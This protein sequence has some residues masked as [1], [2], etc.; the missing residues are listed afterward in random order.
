MVLSAVHIFAWIFGEAVD[1]TANSSGELKT[2]RKETEA[3]VLRLFHAEGWRRNTIAKQLG[4]HHSAV[5]RVLA[6]NGLLP[7]ARRQRKSMSDEFVPFIRQTLEK[8]PKLAATRLHQ[9]VKSR[10]YTGGIDHFRDIVATLRPTPKGEAYLRLSTLPGEQ[11]QCDWAHFGKLTVGNAE[12]R[13]LAFVMVLSWSRNIFLRFYFGDSTANFLRGH[14]EAFEYYNSVPREV[15]YDN[16]KSAVLERIGDAIHFNPDLLS[17]AAHYRFAPK[18]VAVRKANQKGRVERAISYIRTSFFAGREFADIDELNEQA[19]AWCLEESLSRKQPP[20]RLQTVGE[21]FEKERSSLMELPAAPFPVYERKPVQAGKTP[22]VRF[23]LNDYSVPYKYAN[24]RLIV[25]ATLKWVY[26]TNGQELVATHPRVFGKGQTV[27][28]GEHLKELVEF[29]KKAKKHRPMDR[30]RNV[31]PSSEVYYKHAAERGHNLGRLT[32]LLVQLL[33]LYGAAEME[34]AVAETVASGVFH[35]ATIQ[36]I[37]ERNR[38]RRGVVPPVRL[39]FSQRKLEELTV[40]PGGLE[41]YDN[42]AGGRNE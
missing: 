9:M 29:K 39:H 37:L 4:L 6:R 10:G 42:L 24:D 30:I 21:A 3:E 36:R 11:A 17:L 35:S 1:V 5:A 38:R 12:R 25:E 28:D 8:Y 15:L 14:V 18:P 16:L 7:D 20:D 27:E 13:L 19:M 40:I 22:Y 26:I 23:D 2:M 34:A 41:K 32:Q 33:D 31:V